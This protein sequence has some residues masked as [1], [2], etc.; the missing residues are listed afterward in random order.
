MFLFTRGGAGTVLV[1]LAVLLFRAPHAGAQDGMRIADDLGRTLRIDRAPTRVVSLV[2]AVT[3]I[4]YALGAGDVVVGRSAWDDEP[5][6]V[7]AV[8]SVGDALRADPERVLARRPDLVILH[9][10]PDNAGSVERLER[11]GVP[12]LAIRI[13][14]LDDLDRNLLRLGL[15]LGRQEEARALRERIRAELEAVRA[16]T[17]GLPRVS[18]YYDVAWPPAIT[19][20]SGSYLDDLIAIAGGRNV[21]GDVAAPS[22]RVALEAIVLRDPDLILVPSGAAAAGATKPSARP[23]W[24][25][26]GAVGRGDVRAVDAGLLHRL[27]PRVGAAAR[28]LAAV[29][30]P[31]LRLEEEP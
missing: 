2:P 4:L 23:G 6:A 30:H 29:L 20:G 1:V 25:A 18:V 31:E 13:D 11:L 17:E 28:F 19:I 24:R 16:A 3:E 9:A 21:F 14:D 27:G 10:G 22:P 7:L 5:P 12:A 8:P 15:L 26:V